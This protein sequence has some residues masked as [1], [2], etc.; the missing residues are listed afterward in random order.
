M[1]IVE[2]LVALAILGL[3]IVMVKVVGGGSA[4]REAAALAH[5]LATTRW[6]AVTSRAPHTLVEDDGAVYV[7]VGVPPYCERTSPGQLVWSSSQPLAIGWPPSDLVF[8]PHGRPLRCDG[9]AVGN[10]TITLTSRDGS[11]AAVIVSSLGRIRW[12]RR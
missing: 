4:H 12:E 1:S 8:A 9:S 6:L 2:L 10:T 11:R 5:T 7:H 3:A